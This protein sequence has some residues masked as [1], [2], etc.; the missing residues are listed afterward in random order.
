MS[1]SLRKLR[2]Q[3]GIV[4][5]I[6][7]N[8]SFLCLQKIYGLQFF[9]NKP[10]L[11]GHLFLHLRV[12]QAWY[13]SPTVLFLVEISVPCKWNLHGTDSGDSNILGI[14]N[15]VGP[16]T[17]GHWTQE[18]LSKNTNTATLGAKLLI[19]KFHLLWVEPLQNIAKGEKWIFPVQRLEKR[20]DLCLA[21]LLCSK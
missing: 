15:T 21:S 16:N 2:R 19:I 6:F 12:Y 9:D 17:P 18:K 4:K 11:H 8:V 10:K 7:Y 5:E 20:S 14:T 1:L 3:F 13:A